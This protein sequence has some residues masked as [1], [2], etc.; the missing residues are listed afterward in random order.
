M[1][2]SPPDYP[3]MD[4]IAL[5]RGELAKAVGR[6]ESTVRGWMRNQRLPYSRVGGCV[7]IPVRGFEEWLLE[8]RP[9]PADNL[10]SQ[11]AQI[12]T[13]VVGGRGG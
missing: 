13:D 6:S 10:D 1:T 7:L 9:E 3:V 2:G 4:R 12:V 8:H 11:V 5:S